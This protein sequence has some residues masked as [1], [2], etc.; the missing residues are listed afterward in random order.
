MWDFSPEVLLAA[1]AA[2]V[3]A[4]VALPAPDSAAEL[5]PHAAGNGNSGSEA[6]AAAPLGDSVSLNT[7]VGRQAAGRAPAWNCGSTGSSRFAAAPIRCPS[8][9]PSVAAHPTPTRE[10]TQEETGS[11]AQG[12]AE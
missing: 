6:A 9:R 12:F 11:S 8:A 3:L 4:L 7:A 5:W 1:P 10:S 2:K